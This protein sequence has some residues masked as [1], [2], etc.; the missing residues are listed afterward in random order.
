MNFRQEK[1]IENRAEQRLV[2]QK[3]C[4][5]NKNKPSQGFPQRDSPIRKRESVVAGKT[6]EECSDESDRV[7]NNRRKTDL[8]ERSADEHVRQCGQCADEPEFHDLP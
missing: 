8:D 1:K 7:G 4:T 2:G 3:P 5:R 6:Q